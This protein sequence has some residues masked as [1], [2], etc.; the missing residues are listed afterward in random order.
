MGL[1][2]Y[3]EVSSADQG[4]GDQGFGLNFNTELVN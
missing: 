1:N 4:F 2:N 3:Y